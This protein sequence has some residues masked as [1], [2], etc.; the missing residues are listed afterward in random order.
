MPQLLASRHKVA[1]LGSGLLATDGSFIADDASDLPPGPAASGAPITSAILVN[2]LGG[3]EP[4]TGADRCERSLRI[5]M[6]EGKDYFLHAWMKV[7][8]FRSNSTT[9]WN[10]WSQ[11]R[12]SGSPANPSPSPAFGVRGSNFVVVRNLYSQSQGV[13]GPTIVYDPKSY[14]AEMTNTIDAGA[15]ARWH[16]Y[17]YG[18]RWTETTA[19]WLE[20]WRDGKVMI[21]RQTTRTARETSGGGDWR[22]G[23]YG[24]KSMGD[25]DAIYRVAGLEVFDERVPSFGEVIAPPPPPDTGDPCAAIRATLA[26]TVSDLAGAREARDQALARATVAEQKINAART[27]LA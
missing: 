2:Y 5:E 26:Q 15:A 12:D 11:V 20:S 10:N 18:F 8:T 1:D 6:E 4:N 24:D 17:V 16:P 21:P 14:D 7:T 23:Y 19:G 22:I 3:N 13:F 25:P 27:A 9:S